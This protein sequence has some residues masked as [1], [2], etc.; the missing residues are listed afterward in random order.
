M[1]S[2]EDLTLLGGK[3]IISSH[4]NCEW[5]LV[6]IVVEVDEAVVQEEPGVALFAI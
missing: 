5:V 2:A 3:L 4:L 6:S 1:L